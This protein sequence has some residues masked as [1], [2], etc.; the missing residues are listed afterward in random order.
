MDHEIDRRT[1]VGWTGAATG[2]LALAG[3]LGEDGDEN[4]G[5]RNETDEEPNETVD[6]APPF[7]EIED[8]PDA[9]YVPTHRESMRALEPIAAGD[10]RLAPMLSY[11]HPFWTVTG[12]GEDDV[13]HVVPDQMRGVHMMFTLWDAETGVVL[14]V[15]SGAVVRLSRDGERV[16][17]PQSMWPMLSQEM[18]FH[19]GDNVPLEDDGTYAAE[20][21]LPPLSARTTGELAG[22]FDERET[23][24]FEFD[25]DQE[26]R[27]SVT[28]I[29]YFDEQ[30]WGDRGALEPPGQGEMPYSQLP[31]V[32][33]FPGTL[34]VDSDG[35]R[36]DTTADLPR[37][38]DAAFLATVLE[39]DHR[40]ADGDESYLLVSP[41]TPY[42][43][44][45]L[46]NTAPT[47]TVDRDGG[48]VTDEPVPLGQTIDGEYGLHYGTSLEDVALRA[49]DTV[50]LT[51]R[52][53][54][55]VA[56]HQGYDTAFLEMPPIELR[57]PEDDG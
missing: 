28:D 2:A 38:G 14:P 3:C 11:P 17:S 44:V 35:E 30:R 39:S 46:P 21:E 27:E 34:L 18:G 8:K 43:R 10:Y 7:P 32:D 45:P 19:F 53:P 57:V 50:T 54:P 52:S 20:V 29:E 5:E 36:P 22:R 12:D 51:I 16:G 48:A 31:E 42:N 24:T 23:A 6:V 56:R 4:G 37:S 1:F 40:L 15:D 49:G 55:Q 25:Y 33:A 47:V 9:V 41:R 26:F 13:Q